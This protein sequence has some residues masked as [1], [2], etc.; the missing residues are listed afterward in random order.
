MKIN[1][2]CIEVDDCEQNLFR[3]QKIIDSILHKNQI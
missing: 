3:C 2:K 1:H